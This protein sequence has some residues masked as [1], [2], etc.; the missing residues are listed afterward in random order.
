[1]LRL[2]RSERRSWR[3]VVQM[4]ALWPLFWLAAQGAATITGF[5]PVSGQAGTVVTINGSGLLGATAFLFNGVT[6]A[7][8]DI[9]SD[10]QLQVVVPLGAG[11]GPL[12]VV[13]AGLAIAGSGTFTVA[14]FIS[15]FNPASGAHPTS[16]TLFGGNFVMG[17]TTV[18]FA[19]ASPVNFFQNDLNQFI[20]G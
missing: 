18:T 3:R 4:T 9:V 15:S 20:F 5:S 13:V 1:M 10:S 6:Y 7:D 17:G 11:T 14:P 2:Q 16:V 19:G 12:S 8:F